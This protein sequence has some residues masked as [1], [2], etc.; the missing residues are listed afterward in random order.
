MR[1]YSGLD[2]VFFKA[3]FFIPRVI[4]LITSVRDKEKMRDCGVVLGGGP[5]PQKQTPHPAYLEFTFDIFFNIG[6]LRQVFFLI[7]VMLLA[8]SV[9]L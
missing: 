9:S 5:P 2:L 1:D 4:Y 6:A 8:G 3:S 7:S